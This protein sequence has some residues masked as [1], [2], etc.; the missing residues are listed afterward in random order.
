ML[1]VFLFVLLE[2]EY[3]MNRP[4]TLLGLSRYKMRNG[5]QWREEQERKLRTLASQKG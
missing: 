4:S 3:L 2:T 1:I 5:P